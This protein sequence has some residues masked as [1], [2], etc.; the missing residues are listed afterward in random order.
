MK[1]TI[2]I[3]TLLLVSFQISADRQIEFKDEI[4][5][6]TITVPGYFKMVFK[7]NTPILL[8]P[9]ENRGT[10]ARIVETY[11]L[12][13][14]PQGTFNLSS[15]SQDLTGDGLESGKITVMEKSPLRVILKIDGSLGSLPQDKVKVSKKYVIY[16]TGQIYIRTYFESYPV[17]YYV[18]PYVNGLYAFAPADQ[19]ADLVSDPA[20]WISWGG[21]KYVSA[22]ESGYILFHSCDVHPE[23]FTPTPTYPGPDDVRDVKADF[24]A[25]LHYVTGRAYYWG[26]WLHLDSGSADL[27][28]V[29][30]RDGNIQYDLQDSKTVTHLLQIKPDTMNSNTLAQP[31]ALDY[32]Q[33]GV[34]SVIK[35]G[36]VN[37]DPEDLNKDGYNEAEGCYLVKAAGEG[38]EFDLNCTVKRFNPVFKILNWSFSVP[39]KIEANGETLNIGYGYLAQM[40]ANNKDL[41][42]QVCGSYENRVN[43]KIGTTG[44]TNTTNILDSVRVYP[45]PFK[46]S[47]AVNNM[48]KMANIPSGCD[49]GIYAISG[50]KVR[51]IKATDANSVVEW[52]G[53]NENGEPVAAGLYV[54]DVVT[55]DG[56]RKKIKI[57]LVR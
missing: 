52:N 28:Y 49:V 47:M 13:N 57:G 6:K 26:R 4:G 5:K 25:V 45:N 23:H 12:E 19:F 33:P 39:Q 43:V 29:F 48:I 36:T 1:K 17:C 38:V 30:W 53:K 40:A 11:D 21:M 56:N 34:L 42:L 10:G 37:Y 27:N 31:Y 2:H 7:E 54:L 44:N 15:L 24:L 8:Y 35:G 16:P 18:G 9:G 14:D 46:L 50:E 20:I 3:L 22:G 55:P 41:V 32:R 51:S